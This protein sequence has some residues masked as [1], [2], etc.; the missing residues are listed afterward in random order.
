MKLFAAVIIPVMIASGA[1]AAP[2]VSESWVAGGGDCVRWP[3]GGRTTH[4][5]LVAYRQLEAEVARVRRTYPACR[6][7]VYS[8]ECEAQCSVE[9]P[10]R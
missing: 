2:P 10:R 5:K 1:A 8:E 7:D 4:E 3:A 9:E 6:K